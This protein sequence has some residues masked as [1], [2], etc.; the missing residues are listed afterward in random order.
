MTSDCS[1]SHCCLTGLNV[2]LCEI[3]GSFIHTSV[4]CEWIQVNGTACALF[5]M[6]SLQSQSS[7]SSHV[8]SSWSTDAETQRI[9]LLY[10]TELVNN[11]LHHQ[12]SQWTW[13]YGEGLCFLSLCLSSLI[14][15][16]ISEHLTMDGG[17]NPSLWRLTDELTAFLPLSLHLFSV[18][19][20]SCGYF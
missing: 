2:L 20:V 11:T 18:C 14:W 4:G 15:L 17:C 7:V 10:V 13:T 12:E 3:W 16:L 19:C 5:T 9:L 1:S 8:T 6:C